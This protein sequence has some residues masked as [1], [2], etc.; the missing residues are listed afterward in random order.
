M[1]KQWAVAVVRCINE[2]THGGWDANEM[3]WKSPCTTDWRSQFTNESMNEW[4]SELVS[5]MSQWMNASMNQYISESTTQLINERVN[6]WMHDIASPGVS[7]SVNQRMNEL[8]SWW[9]NESVTEW[10]NGW[11]GEWLD[12]WVSYFFVELLLHWATPSLRYLLSQLLL[13]EHLCYFFFDPDLSCLP[14]SSSIAFAAQFFSARSCYN[15]FSNLQL[16]SRIAQ[17]WVALW[18]RTTCRAAITLRLAP[19]SCNP[20][21]QE[22]SRS[23]NSAD[24]FRLCCPLVFYVFLMN[25]SSRAHFADLVSQSAPSMPVF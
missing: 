3:T 8:V 16:Q 19:S 1:P 5:Q 4:T 17:E 2:W 21:C 9:T 15:A 10:I 7:E 12:G 14:A 22:R 11:T 20:A 25:S 18:S 24:L 6:Q 13:S 23:A